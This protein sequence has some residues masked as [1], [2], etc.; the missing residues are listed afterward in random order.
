M[1]WA[2]HVHLELWQYLVLATEQ[3]FSSV[4]LHQD[5]AQAPHVDGQV[6]GYAQQHLR[7]AVEPALNVVEH[8]WTQRESMGH[9]TCECAP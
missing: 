8:L 2:G 3:W 9:I 1:L 5:A 6:V 4:H 7:R